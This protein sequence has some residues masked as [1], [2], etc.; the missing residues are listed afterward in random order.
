MTK[1][2][3]DTLVDDGQYAHIAHVLRRPELA[4]KISVQ[5]V[6]CSRPVPFEGFSARVVNAVLGRP[7]CL[8]QN[9]FVR[10]SS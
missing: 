5:W 7:H 10:V 2:T 6:I 4:D 3:L 1:L 9:P 8:L